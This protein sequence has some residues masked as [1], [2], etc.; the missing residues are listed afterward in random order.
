MFTIGG[1][2]SLSNSDL[3]EH[4]CQTNTKNDTKLQGNVMIN[5]S[6]RLLLKH[7]WHQL[8][9]DLLTT[10]QQKQTNMIPLKHLVQ[11]NHSINFKKHWMSNIIVLFVG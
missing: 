4:G 10:V 9:K 2:Q 5:S 8:L 6:T 7:Q 11:E 1:D 3:Y